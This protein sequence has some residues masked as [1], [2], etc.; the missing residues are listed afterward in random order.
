MAAANNWP[1]L[2]VARFALGFAV[3]AKSSTTPVYAA[4]SA[5]KNIR[6]ALTMMWQVCSR[7]RPTPCRLKSL[8]L[9]IDVD[10]IRHHAWICCVCGLPR[11]RL[12]RP[13]HPVAMDAGININPAV[14]RHVS[15]L[16]VS[17]K[18]P[19]VCV[20]ILH[21]QGLFVSQCTNTVCPGT[22]KRDDGQKRSR[23]LADFVRTR[24]K[25]L[26][27]CTTRPSC[28]KSKQLSVRAS[29]FGKNSLVSGAT[30]ARPRAHSLSCSCNR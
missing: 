29:R 5:P 22:W 8:T 13:K 16:S 25:L 2:L 4:E 19:L 23:L 20:K 1:N 3:G 7:L 28:W 6:G 30:A 12:P 15:G 14:H 11:H 26:A 17:R 27:T 18:S 9:F 21:V 10:C 24:S